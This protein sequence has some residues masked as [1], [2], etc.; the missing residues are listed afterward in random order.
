M[1]SLGTAPPPRLGD[2]FV[3]VADP[4]TLWTVRKI[5]QLPHVPPHV[6]LVGQ[7]LSRRT[8]L[9]SEVVLRDRRLY[10]PAKP[11]AVEEVESA[12]PQPRRGLGARA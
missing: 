2:R 10:R 1:L 4:A 11:A 12:R 9:V 5:V 3:R 6:Q 8:I 7:G